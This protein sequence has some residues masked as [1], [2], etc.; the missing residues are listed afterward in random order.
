MTY[1]KVLPLGKTLIHKF[2]FPLG[3]R[4]LN[5]TETETITLKEN[6][7][8]LLT[9]TLVK[10][11][12]FDHLHALVYD[13]LLGEVD[14]IGDSHEKNKAFHHLRVALNEAIPLLN[15]SKA[16]LLHEIS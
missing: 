9:P 5:K 8:P 1:R 4:N 2:Q 10:L 3:E 13:K 16:S 12:E 14:K 7:T 15:I 6:R 11:P